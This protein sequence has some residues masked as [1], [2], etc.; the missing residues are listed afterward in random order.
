MFI[1]YTRSHHILR[2]YDFTSKRVITRAGFMKMKADGKD[3][4]PQKTIKISLT[5][6]PKIRIVTH[7]ETAHPPSNN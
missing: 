3:Y 2:F 1:G 5:I 7:P 4:S 6:F